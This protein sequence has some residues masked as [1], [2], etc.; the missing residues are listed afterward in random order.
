MVN[1]IYPDEHELNKANPKESQAGF[2]DLNISDKKGFVTI[3][4]HD[5]IDDC[6][7]VL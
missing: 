4:L 3:K 7:L 6:D 1:T 2:L 5:T